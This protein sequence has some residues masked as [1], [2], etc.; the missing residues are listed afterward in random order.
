MSPVLQKEN[1]ISVGG[2][3]SFLEDQSGGRACAIG[4]VKVI[5]GKMEACDGKQGKGYRISGWIISAC[6]D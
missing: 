1:K 5:V 3:Q 6:V 2:T 4:G